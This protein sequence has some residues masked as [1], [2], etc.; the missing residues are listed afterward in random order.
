DDLNEMII[1]YKIPFDLHP[2][3]PSEEFVMSELL[4]DDIGSFH[5]AGSFGFEQGYYFR[6]ALSVFAYKADDD[7]PSSAIIVPSLLSV[8]IRPQFALTIIVLA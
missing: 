3:L 7:V 2:L 5:S 8:M 1:K 4:D 6:S